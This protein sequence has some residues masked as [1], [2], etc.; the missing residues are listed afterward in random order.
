MTTYQS[1]LFPNGLQVLTVSYT[2]LQFAHLPVQKDVLELALLLISF[3]D[4][5]RSTCSQ[6]PS[7]N[8]VRIRRIK[9]YVSA[10]DG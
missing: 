7:K 8:K 1:S 5:E 9:L 3:S 6:D 2:V 10:F 4:Q